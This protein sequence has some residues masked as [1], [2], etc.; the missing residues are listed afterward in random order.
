[1][2]VKSFNKIC[3]H[4]GKNAT[5]LAIIINWKVKKKWESRIVTDNIALF[6][7]I[8]KPEVKE[9]VTKK[10]VRFASHVKFEKPQRLVCFI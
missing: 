7:I 3:Y 9:K 4:C 2:N 8:A 6:L 10:K 1:M 5:G